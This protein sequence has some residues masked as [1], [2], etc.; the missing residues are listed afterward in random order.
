MH[1]FLVACMVVFMSVSCTDKPVS[2]SGDAPVEAEDF[3]AAFPL[4]T[5]PLR[6]ADT[7]FIK[8]AD[9]TTISY[10]VF[11]QFIADSVLVNEFGKN[12]KKISIHPLGKIEKETELYLLANCTQNKKTTLLV[13]LLDKQNKFL[14]SVELL[15]LANKDGYI[16]S[17]SITSEPTF[18]I[19]R[20]RINVAAEL[21]YTK[22]GYAFNSASGKFVEVMTDSN[23]D[24]KRINEII[25]PIDTLPRKNKMSGD[26]TKDKRNYIS[27]RDGSSSSKYSFFIHFE[28]DGGACT[29]ELKGT[30]TMR[31]ATHAYFQ[32]SG[33][34]CVIDFTFEGRNITV[35]EQDNCGNHRGI[36]CFFNDSYTKRKENKPVKKNK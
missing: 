30:M 35:K 27:V 28:K 34:P 26:Y 25:N 10:T 33:D 5:L 15:K 12:A 9:T 14:A 17:V 7:N 20:E 23:E 1:K 13:F 29:G 16:H 21:L 18:I 3:I 31:D 6:I 36:K 22:H 19:N 11:T 8:M 24:L 32:E 4:L 2:L